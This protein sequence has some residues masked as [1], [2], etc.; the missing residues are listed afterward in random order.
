MES[1]VQSNS[2]SED[3]DKLE[4]KTTV[5]NE[6]K[7]ATITIKKPSKRQSNFDKDDSG[8]PD[9]KK[10]KKKIKYPPSVKD[11]KIKSDD[12]LQMMTREDRIDYLERKRVEI[13]EVYSKWERFCKKLQKKKTKH[14]KK[15]AMAKKKEKQI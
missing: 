14:D 8:E 3:L 9:R 6:N 1:I 2:D 4:K 13:A 12:E 5:V 15:L 11:I 7:V 10:M